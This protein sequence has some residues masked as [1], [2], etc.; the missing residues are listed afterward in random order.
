MKAQVLPLPNSHATILPPKYLQVMTISKLQ[1]NT[2]QP[3][4]KS[5]VR[6]AEVKVAAL[7]AHVLSQEERAESNFK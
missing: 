6:R 4:V 5:D 7:N 3:V 2:H 1:T